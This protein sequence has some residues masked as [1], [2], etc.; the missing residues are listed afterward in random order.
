MKALTIWQP[1]ADLCDQRRGQAAR[2]ASA[3]H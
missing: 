2:G 1:F 3:T